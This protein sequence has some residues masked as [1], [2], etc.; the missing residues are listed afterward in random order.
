LADCLS[1]GATRRL[2]IAV[3]YARVWIPEADN[4][5]VAVVDQRTN[6]IQRRI[7]VP[8][9]PTEAAVGAGAVW[10]T[11]QHPRSAVWKLDPR[12]LRPL[13]SVEVQSRALRVA[14]G[15]DAVWVTS[16]TPGQPGPGAVT[17][18]DPKTMRVVAKL[19]LGYRPDGVA[20]A[21]GRVWVAVAPT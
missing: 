6:R 19:D 9:G 13:A 10:V 2:E 8:D 18:I 11:T 14:A 5:D 16:S 7:A 4:N 3:G 21:Y 1:F 17:R 15:E 12:T 20:V